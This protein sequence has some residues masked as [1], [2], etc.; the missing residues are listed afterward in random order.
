MTKEELTQLGEN[1]KARNDAFSKINGG[2]IDELD[3]DTLKGL[4]AEYAQYFE[5]MRKMGEIVAYI[6]ETPFLPSEVPQVQ[7]DGSVDRSSLL[8]VEFPV[9]GGI[10]TYMTGKD[11]PYRG[12]PY[13]EHVDKI[14]VVKKITRAA[15][16]GL[17]HSF[18]KRRL[19]L[20]TLI[21]SLW[22]FRD[23][24][25][26]GVYTFYR[27]IERFRWKPIMY[28]DSIRELYRAMDS[29]DEFTTQLRDLLCM[30]LECDNAYRYRFQDIISELN[31]ESL[32]KNPRKELLRLLSIMSG[33]EKTQ[34]IKD[35]WRL[36][37]Y[38]VSFYLW[39]DKRLLNV[40]ANTLKEINIEKIR[41]SVEDRYYCV[42]RKDYRFGF[43]MEEQLQTSVEETLE[44]EVLETPAEVP[45]EQS[46]ETT[47]E[48]AT[49]PTSTPEALAET[50]E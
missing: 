49:E 38:I 37:K 47:A 5:N 8:K 31:K 25:S 40:I 15:M 9:E 28:S 6:K 16:S 44:K 27:M 30:F 41:L 50:V 33:R 14:D 19:S 1:M 45:A 12:F 13:Y 42:P 35:T 11:Y 29:A 4:T 17:Y 48:V 46:A 18:K 23:F 39:F 2:K 20:I 7:E 21:P 43:K 3:Q 34:E 22:V 24:V 26:T 36:V 32:E 10:L